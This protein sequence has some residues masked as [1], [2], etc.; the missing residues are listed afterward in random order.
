MKILLSIVALGPFPVA[1]M[2]VSNRKNI[3]ILEK[4]LRDS[5]QV[6]INTVLAAPVDAP[7]GVAISLYHGMSA[8]DVHRVQL[9]VVVLGAA[10]CQAILERK[11]VS[12][13]VVCFTS[14]KP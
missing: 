14:A 5:A 11:T 1:E 12:G 6:N 13:L 7:G 4:M 3:A 10:N 2:C 9:D 8:T